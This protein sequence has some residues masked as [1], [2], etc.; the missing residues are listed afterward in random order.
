[1]TGKIDEVRIYNISLPDAHI[2]AL[3]NLGVAKK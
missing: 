2:K 1:M 3:Y